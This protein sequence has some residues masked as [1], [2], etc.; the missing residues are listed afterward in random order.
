MAYR[1]ELTRDAIYRD[2]KNWYCVTGAGA[3][4]ASRPH[5]DFCKKHASK[6]VLDLGCATGV[7]CLELAKAGYECVGADINAEY[8]K[9]ARARGVDAHHIEGPLPFADKSF[10]SVVM[11]E[12]L[13][14]ARDP[15]ALLKEV[16]RVGRKNVIITVPDC[17]GFEKLKSGGLIYAHF[18]E[19]DHVNF[20]TKDSLERLLKQYFTKVTVTQELP[21]APWLLSE[22]K[23]QPLG[24]LALLL[25]KAVSLFVRLGLFR[26]KYYTCLFAVA[27]IG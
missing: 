25:R 13:E 5:L 2:S 7:Y 1:P 22:T 4:E 3:P 15:E 16:R 24:I 17:G 18:L 11:I 23:I 20:F 10:D 14:H 12:V 9:A 19:L 6:R 21:L 26:P 8:V 27:E